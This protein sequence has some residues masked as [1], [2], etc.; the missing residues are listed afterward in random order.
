MK[1]SLSVFL[2]LL[3]TLAML[4][5]AFSACAFAANR[6]PVINIVGEREVEVWKEDGTHY[7]PTEAMADE[8][9]DKAIEELTPV[10]VKA[11]LTNNYDEWSRLALEKLTPI[12]DEIR[13]APDGT[14]P[15]NTSPYLWA[16]MPQTLP[17]P[18]AVNYYYGYC[19]DFRNSPLDEA[20][21]LHEFIQSVKEKTG[22]DK[23]ILSSRCGSTSLSACYLY[24]Y[25]AGDIAKIIF[26]ASTLLGTPHAD[27]LLSGNLKVKGNALYY[28]LMEN[29]TLS[30]MDASLVKFI[31]AML[32]ALNLNGSADDTISLLL[33]IY[34]K[35][36]ESFLAPFLRS[37]Y[38][39]CGNYIASVSDH[40]DEYVNYIFPTAELKAEYAPILTKAAEYHNNVQKHLEDLLTGVRDAGVPVYFLAFYGEPSGF[41]VSE[42]SA[43]VGDELVD[44]NW[45]SF[46]AT[47]ANF[48]EKLADSSLAG[49]QQAGLGRYLSPDGQIDA[50]TCLFPET[51]WFIKNMRHAFH[52]NDLH[53]FIRLI[54][55]SDD[56]T[57]TSNPDYPQFLTVVG[58]HKSLAPAQA[59]NENDLDVSAW[60][61]D[62]K[63]TTGFFAKVVAFFAKIIAF[64]ARLFKIIK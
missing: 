46:G 11:F 42:R 57:V 22:S 8:V 41:P 24:K 49:R 44:A 18:G 5:P 27:A 38:G 54:A 2:A 19:W 7:A 62:M 1:K 30:S 63:G 48:P 33:R 20:D 10:F 31:N 60:Q 16:D 36:K 52:A 26:S 35:I 28:Y 13:P 58:N 32:F 37:Y 21:A 12:Y 39:I 56:M 45:Q 34:D 53:N 50:S 9:V 14:L 64:F 47:V 6:V 61:Q 3:F 29:D 17:E 55:W 59:V 43:M 51:T 25:G 23:V 15:E 40:F 4:L